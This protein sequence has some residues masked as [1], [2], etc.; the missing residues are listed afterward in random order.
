MNSDVSRT[1]VRQLLNRNKIIILVIEALLL[2][3]H[4]FIPSHF[5]AIRLFV[6][7]TSYILIP[8]FLLV[9][10]IGID[11][12]FEE[13]FG[14]SL[15]FG[16]SIQI[17]LMTL[18][19]SLLLEPIDLIMFPF[20][21]TIFVFIMLLKCR[22]KMQLKLH[23]DSLPSSL[24]IILILAI[25]VRLYYFL[26]NVSSMGIDAGLYCDMARTIISSGRYSSKIINDNLLDPFLNV[27]G[28]TSYPVTV[29][30]ISIFFLIGDISYTSAKM[31]VFFAGIL[32]VFLIYAT[33]KELFG[34]K[35]A[36]VAGFISSIS[37]TLSYYS[38]ILH[39]PEI[40]ASLYSLATI[41]F[42]I[43]GIKRDSKAFYI[44]TSIF[45]LM[46]YGAWGAQSYIILLVCLN[47]VVLFWGYKS[48][49]FCFFFAILSLVLFYALRV[50]S[51]L[52]IHVA[53]TIALIITLIAVYNKSKDK[54]IQSSCIYF[55]TTTLLYQLF[56]LRRHL[57]PNVQILASAKIVFEEPWNV[58][59]VFTFNQRNALIDFTYVW[60]TIFRFWNSF[61]VMSTP[62]LFLISIFSLLSFSH[63]KKKLSLLSM[64]GAI[65][66]LYSYSLPEYVAW[67]GEVFSDRFLILSVCFLTILSGSITEIFEKSEQIIVTLSARHHGITLRF[68]RDK[69]SV[70]CIMILVVISV[71]PSHIAYLAKFNEG[72]SDALEWYGA[73][74]ISWLKSNVSSNAIILTGEPRRLAW[75]VDKIFVGEKHPSGTLGLSELLQL[76]ESYNVSHV[77]VD[78]FLIKY[79]NIDSFIKSLYFIPL[80]IGAK[81]PLIET[82]RFLN[83]LQELVSCVNVSSYNETF[84]TYFLKLSFEYSDNQSRK[85]RIYE[86]IKSKCSLRVE[87]IKTTDWSAGNYGEFVLLDESPSFKLLIGEGKDYAFTFQKMPLNLT[88]KEESIT[89]LFFKVR[90]INDAKIDRIEF[91]DKGKIV[92]VTIP[93]YTNESN[94]LSLNVVDVKRIDNIRIVISGKPKGYVIFDCFILLTMSEVV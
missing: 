71:F 50:A 3:V 25:L 48:K 21:T 8:G 42:L 22:G 59:N 89:F 38:S 40:L 57:I 39:G 84:S 19:W 9:K 30:S 75:M 45:T 31:V 85:V 14:L 69:I 81:I 5:L 54:K 29:F 46:T 74:T 63:L 23:I 51:A 93:T 61:I 94:I 49:R 34:Q 92:C 55:L 43:L 33:T 65:S 64:I 27:K 78:T 12:K 80:S 1:I 20:L 90:E 72:Y 82:D 76:I 68:E 86:I 91:W 2:A 44:L 6:G 77:I 15:L 67:F 53:L 79:R 83:I 16:F 18:F 60:R 24:F 56:L 58:L 87:D 11:G 62:I 88:L 26:N 73:P 35:A 13:T 32:V 36:Q 7:V 37:P 47:V 66:L 70:I 28:L 17:L 4:Y 52:P 41:Y 10:I